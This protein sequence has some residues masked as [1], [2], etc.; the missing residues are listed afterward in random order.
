MA[1]KTMWDKYPLEIYDEGSE[2]LYEL[3][4]GRWT[5]IYDRKTGEGTPLSRVIASYLRD[6]RSDPRILYLRHK[7]GDFFFTMARKGRVVR[8]KVYENGAL[9]RDYYLIPTPY[10]RVNFENLVSVIQAYYQDP[11]SGAL[12]DHM[13]SEV[14]VYNLSPVGML[15][16]AV[17]SIVKRKL[18]TL[19]GFVILWMDMEKLREE[20]APKGMRS[21]G[22]EDITSD[23]DN[24]AY[25]R[26]GSRACFD[27][28]LETLL[29]AEVD[30]SAYKFKR[31]LYRDILTSVLTR[32]I[33]LGQPLLLMPNYPREGDDDSKVE[34]VAALVAGAYPGAVSQETQKIPRLAEYPI[35]YV[36]TREWENMIHENPE[37][38]TRLT[39]DAK[40]LGV[41]LDYEG[42]IVLTSDR[43]FAGTRNA[44]TLPDAL[45]I[46][47]SA[48]LTPVVRAKLCD[49]ESILV[50]A[51]ENALN[52]HIDASLVAEKCSNAENKHICQVEVLCT[53]KTIRALRLY[54]LM[55]GENIKDIEKHCHEN[56]KTMTRTQAEE[57]K[58]EKRWSWWPW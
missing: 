47:T 27:I 39:E 51:I 16:N 24:R 41:E 2:E 57:Q 22:D 29:K 42:R 26:E 1:G 37:A 6:E 23:G 53:L 46:R 21:Y 12:L 5:L 9:L 4:N 58:S 44:I 49:K 19:N 13:N 50:T 10:G 18:G 52:N 54:S 20:Y 32:W 38:I 43:E 7:Q 56:N 33:R 14:A 40:I 34:F 28:A 45:G 55:A 15:G 35:Y 48:S 25:Q 36:L 3:R 11:I 31:E 30:E 17:L 8:L